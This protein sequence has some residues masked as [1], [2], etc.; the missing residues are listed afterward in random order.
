MDVR[1][2]LLVLGT[3]AALATWGCAGA[4]PDGEKPITGKTVIKCPHCGQIYEAEKGLYTS[5]N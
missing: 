1:K 3:L 4:R 2:I 5:G